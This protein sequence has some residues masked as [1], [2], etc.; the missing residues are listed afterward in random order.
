MASFDYDVP[1]IG[2][3]SNGNIA[4]LRAAA[5]GYRAGVFESAGAGVTYR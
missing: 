5:R 3:G 1:V 2:S 4:A